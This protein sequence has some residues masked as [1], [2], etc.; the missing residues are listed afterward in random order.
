MIVEICP[1]AVIIFWLRYLYDLRR[2]PPKS[3]FKRG[4]WNN[5]LV[6][7]LLRG[8]RGDRSL[9]IFAEIPKNRICEG[10]IS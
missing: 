10:K 8:V 1:I 9:N 5:N 4:T 3:P 2:D 7:P 6:P